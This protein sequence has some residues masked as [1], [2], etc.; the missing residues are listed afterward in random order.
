MAVMSLS[1]FHIL[2]SIKNKW[3]DLFLRIT[4]LD[5]WGV[6]K[7]KPYHQALVDQRASNKK[8]KCIF[9]SKSRVLVFSFGFQ[10]FWERNLLNAKGNLYLLATE[11]WQICRLNCWRR[12]CERWWWPKGL[13]PDSFQSLRWPREQGLLDQM[14][15]P[16]V[17]FKNILRTAFLTIYFG[18]IQIIRDT[19]GGGRGGPQSVIWTF[20]LLLKSLILTLF[21]V[22]SHAWE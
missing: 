8:G 19:L 9:L 16:F 14:C 6:Y 21:E 20:L 2:L 7:N 13:H 10:I 12:W 15:W 18:A 3:E 17:N 1:S 22:K 5:K 4:N 11:Y